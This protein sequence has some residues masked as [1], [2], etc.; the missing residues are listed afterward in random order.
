[1]EVE[2]IKENFKRGQRHDGAGLGKI[3]TALC[4]GMG[5]GA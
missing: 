1:M 4:N 2:P 5:A 3:R